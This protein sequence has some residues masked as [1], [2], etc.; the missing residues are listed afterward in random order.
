MLSTMFPSLMSLADSLFFSQPAQVYH[1]QFVSEC[2]FM[3]PLHVA[4]TEP[5]FP[6]IENETYKL[7]I[8]L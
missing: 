8:F 5:I 4:T 2:V 7:I 3:L 6:K 1:Y